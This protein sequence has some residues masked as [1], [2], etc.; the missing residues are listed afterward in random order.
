MDHI[1]R[2]YHLI[3]PFLSLVMI[4]FISARSSERNSVTYTILEEGPKSSFKQAKAKISMFRTQN[5]F[6][7]FYSQIH[8][9]VHPKPDPPAVNFDQNFVVYITF[10]EQKSAGYSIDLRT[11]YRRN[12][13]LVIKAILITPPQDSF[14]AQVITQP[15]QL[16]VVPKEDYKRV[17]LVNETGEV[18]DFKT[19][20]E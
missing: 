7:A 12:S 3:I 16:I 1:K 15:Y 13:T 17:D 6:Q 20:K 4:L 19:L 10:G 14:Q 18:Q 11:I 9:N 8:R 5:E 2:H